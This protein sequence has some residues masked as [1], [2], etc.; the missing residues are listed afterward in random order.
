MKQKKRRISIA[1]TLSKSCKTKTTQCI[2]E[3][4]SFIQKTDERVSRRKVMLQSTEKLIKSYKVA[5]SLQLAYLPA[6]TSLTSA[7]QNF[8]RKWKTEPYSHAQKLASYLSKCC[9]R[10][11]AVITWS[12]AQ[13]ASKSNI[14]HIFHKRAE[15]AICLV[16][17]SYV[18]EKIFIL[19]H[20]VSKCG[21]TSFQKRKPLIFYDFF[22]G[23][24]DS[25][26]T[27]EQLSQTNKQINSLMCVNDCGKVFCPPRD[28]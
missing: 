21:A 24:K 23:A 14:A 25:K 15:L 5:E 2:R 11:H 27:K 26:D 19:R 8:S 13:T 20:Q 22:P 1:K 18:S 17:Q 3:W 12:F 9:C 28:R 7:G 4:I 6:E 16:T 10:N